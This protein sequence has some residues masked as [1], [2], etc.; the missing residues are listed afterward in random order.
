MLEKS[1]MRIRCL[2]SKMILMQVSTKLNISVSR[3][4]SAVSNQMLELAIEFITKTGIQTKI[5]HV[6]ETTLEHVN[7]IFFPGHLQ[8]SYPQKQLQ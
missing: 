1:E 5:F 4:L 8:W 7:L 6:H 3:V 2:S